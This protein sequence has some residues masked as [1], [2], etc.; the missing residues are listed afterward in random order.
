MDMENV[1]SL[2]ILS[3]QGPRQVQSVYIH[4][5][6]ISHIHCI[7]TVFT[8][9]PFLS[10]HNPAL[11]HA[12]LSSFPVFSAHL[13]LHFPLLSSSA[14]P[15]LAPYIL[16]PSFG[17]SLGWFEEMR[18]CLFASAPHHFLY[19]SLF[20]VFSPAT[21]SRFQPAS[22]HCLRLAH[23]LFLSPL[24]SSLSL[25]LCLSLCL[26]PSPA[27]LFFFAHAHSPLSSLLF[28]LICCPS[29]SSRFLY[30]LADIS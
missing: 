4:S 21:S 16:T 2:S 11:H 28:S 3:I 20:T 24:S 9:C 26:S 23:S 27:L 18:S 22:P 5:S 6:Y 1:S 10:A 7:P 15:R 30:S 25:S 8:S 29:C 14:V 12:V 13:L 17:L 19:L